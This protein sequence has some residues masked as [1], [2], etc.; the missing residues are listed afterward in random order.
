MS[1]WHWRVV[2]NEGLRVM[3]VFVVLS[4]DIRQRQNSLRHVGMFV[5]APHGSFFIQRR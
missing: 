3:E 2:Q 1:I 4:T 5:I